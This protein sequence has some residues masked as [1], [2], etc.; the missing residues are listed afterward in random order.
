MSLLV[1]IWTAHR[2][3]L[4]PIPHSALSSTCQKCL[5]LLKSLTVSCLC[6]GWGVYTGTNV[7]VKLGQAHQV[8]WKP[9][10]PETIDIWLKDCS[11]SVLLERMVTSTCLHWRWGEWSEWRKGGGIWP[12]V[13]LSFQCSRYVTCLGRILLYVRYEI[14]HFSPDESWLGSRCSGSFE[15]EKK[16]CLVHPLKICTMRFKSMTCAC[17]G[18]PR[19][20]MYWET[21]VH[22]IMWW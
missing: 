18:S 21:H 9:Q 10:Q 8:M 14:L 2:P 1:H 7:G 5:P 16:R 22:R 6:H 13:T 3:T 17:T 19:I 15:K 20:S 12:Q 4:I 11:L